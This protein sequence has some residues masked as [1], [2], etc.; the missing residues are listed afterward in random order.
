MKRINLK[1]LPLDSHTLLTKEQLKNIFGGMPV[2]GVPGPCS[3]SCPSGTFA[4][5]KTGGICFCTN[6]TQ[7]CYAGGVGAS[8]CSIS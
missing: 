4:C 6:Q 5:C 2:T 7:L 1:D 8:G 3:I